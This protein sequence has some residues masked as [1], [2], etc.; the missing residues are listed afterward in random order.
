[1]IWARIQVLQILKEMSLT[2][3]FHSF[4]SS[5]VRS[6]DIFPNYRS[7]NFSLSNRLAWTHQRFGTS[8]F[9]TIIKSVFL[10]EWIRRSGYQSIV[11]FVFFKTAYSI[12]QHSV[13]IY[14]MIYCIIFFFFTKDFFRI[15]SISPLMELMYLT[16][17]GIRNDSVSL[18]NL[19]FFLCSF[20]LLFLLLFSFY[21]ILCCFTVF[22]CAYFSNPTLTHE[23]L[24][25]G[26]ID[27]LLYSIYY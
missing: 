14:D 5:R 6:S 15:L 3:N 20:S 12:C 18:F 23:V 11:S 22:C 4:L 25:W 10:L 16:W 17:A 26:L 13:F 21:L 1:M 2:H 27:P 19:N 8:S 9:F 24:F 7:L